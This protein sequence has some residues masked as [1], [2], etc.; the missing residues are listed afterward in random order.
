LMFSNLLIVLAVE[1]GSSP[2]RSASYSV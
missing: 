1:A 2:V